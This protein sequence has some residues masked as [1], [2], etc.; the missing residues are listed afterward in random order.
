MTGHEAQCASRNP[1]RGRVGHVIRPRH[2]ATWAKRPP[3]MAQPLQIP[4]GV[5]RGKQANAQFLLLRGRIS[6]R[7]LP[8]KENNRASKRAMKGS[9]NGF[10]R[11]SQVALPDIL[12]LRGR[13]VPECSGSGRDPGGVAGRPMRPGGSRADGSHDQEAGAKPKAVRVGGRLRSRAAGAFQGWIRRGRDEISDPV[14][15][16]PE[17]FSEPDCREGARWP[18]VATRCFGL[19]RYTKPRTCEGRWCTRKQ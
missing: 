5:G 15:R 9:F 3:T 7:A 14:G 8:L 2:G 12:D 13:F 6:A 4:N 16:Q 10:G 19:V 17:R 1:A 18:A 11:V